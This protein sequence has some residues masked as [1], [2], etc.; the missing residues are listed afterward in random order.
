MKWYIAKCP[1]GAE[2]NALKSFQEFLAKANLSDCLGE[3]LIP[4]AQ[5]AA[6]KNE[7]KP[8]R[9][10]K[11]NMANYVFL[12]LNLSQTVQEI[13]SKVET[14][15]LML[16]E[17]LNPIVTPDAEIE[18]MKAKIASTS[19]QMEQAFQPGQQVKVLEAPFEDF[20]AIIEKVDEVKQIANVSVPILGRQISVELPFKSIKRITD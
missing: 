17:D 6:A 15:N 10:L 16:D 13:F 7:Q 2:N 14:M 20:T 9:S 5:I 12:Q 3:I 1:T 4:Y 19:E 8:R 18:A 11:S